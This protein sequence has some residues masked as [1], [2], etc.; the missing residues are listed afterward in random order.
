MFYILSKTVD[1]LLMPLTLAFIAFIYA[2]F[3]KNRARGRKVSMMA[4]VWLYLVSN[5]IRVNELL[6]YWE[7]KPLDRDSKYEVAV[8][9]TGGIIKSYH[10][11][12]K[13]IW[14]GKSGDRALQAFE[15]YKRGRIKK[16]II[17][18]GEGS[19]RGS[20][21]NNAENEGIRQYLIDSGVAAADII[22]DSLS[23]NTRQNAV[24]TAKILK[25]QFKTNQC[26]VITSAF[27]MPR[28]VGCFNKEGIT[29]V[30]WPGHYLQENGV[31]WFDK[32]FPS[33]EA[34]AYFYLVWHEMIGCMVYKL[35]GYI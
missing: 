13:Y 24:N 20:K 5:P 15:L 23:L 34:L 22:Q 7:P 9:L 17:S 8:V 19:L 18:G 3:T 1:V 31:I 2:M 33:E 21:V 27:H 4:L 35:M 29:V 26:V 25:N 30:P 14:F 32:L 16:I 10:R 28:S 6:K 12:T 11:P